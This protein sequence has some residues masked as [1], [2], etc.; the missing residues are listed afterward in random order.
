MKPEAIRRLMGAL[1]NNGS[2]GSVAPK[3]L[4]WDFFGHKKTKTIDSLGLVLKSGLKFI[5]F[6]QGME[7]DG[8][9]KGFEILGPSGAAGLFR[10]QALER[11][12]E[13]HDDNQDA[14]YFDERFFMYK[15]DCDLAYRLFLAGFGSRLV[16]EAIVYHD[17]TAAISGQGIKDFWRDRQSKSRQV[18]AWS[19]RNQHLIFL[20]YWKKQNF[21]NKIIITLKILFL[22][23]FSLILE[24]FLLKEYICLLKLS[25]GLTNIK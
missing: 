16:P 15:E 9:E 20:K 14:Q 4:R 23:I 25:K 5:D 6:R 24:Q 1:D 22:L 21:V 8:K 19:F 10:L 13:K 7:D 17:R 2:L 3:I 12:A 18:R 11:I